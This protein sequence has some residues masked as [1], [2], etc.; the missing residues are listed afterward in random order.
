[1]ASQFRALFTFMDFEWKRIVIVPNCL[2]TG[3]RF[4]LV[5]SEGPSHLVDTT[6]KGYKRRISPWI[7]RKPNFQILSYRS[8]TRI[9]LSA[10]MSWLRFQQIINKLS[11]I[12][13][14]PKRRPI[15][16]RLNDWLAK[17]PR[18]LTGIV[19]KSMSLMYRMTQSVMEKKYFGA[20]NLCFS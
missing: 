19:S 6:S 17:K 13:Y 3:P 12:H 14:H 9:L 16:S 7:Q 1:M 11:N 5:S 2:V 10:M 20:T 4:F 18:T 15:A 8:K